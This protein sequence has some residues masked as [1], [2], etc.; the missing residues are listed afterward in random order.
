MPRTPRINRTA[1]VQE[2]NRDA[3]PHTPVPAARPGRR[4]A[5]AEADTA[6]FPRRIRVPL[7]RG[8]VGAAVRVT[9]FAGL[10]VSAA[11]VAGAISAEV[12]GNISGQDGESFA[13]PAML[14]ALAFAGTGGAL[15][16]AG[17]RMIATA[18]AAAA[19]GGVAATGGTS[20]PGAAV[21]ADTFDVELPVT[22]SPSPE[23]PRIRRA[24]PGE[25]AQ[26]GL[27]QAIAG[28]IDTAP[29]ASPDIENPPP[30]QYTV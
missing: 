14:A 27:M 28:E 16:A 19:P 23:P 29:A 18:D 21:A 17:T 30:A 8:R 24:A 22:R 5:M 10:V 15:V 7:D 9:G 12:A 25:P 20:A 1:A 11:A 2:P 4:N 3:A 26:A 13:V 6:R